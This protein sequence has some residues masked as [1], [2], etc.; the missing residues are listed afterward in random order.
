ML[1]PPLSPSLLVQSSASRSLWLHTWHPR[2]G[3]GLFFCTTWCPCVGFTWWHRIGCRRNNKQWSQ[4]NLF[5]V[6]PAIA[7]CKRNAPQAY[8]TVHYNVEHFSLSAIF[9]LKAS[10][11]FKQPAASQTSQTHLML[12]SKADN[13]TEIP[14]YMPS[15]WK[16]SNESS[17]TQCSGNHIPEKRCETCPCDSLWEHI[18]SQKP[19]CVSFPSDDPLYNEW[20]HGTIKP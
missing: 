14:F 1:L 18:S 16:A 3:R 12:L 11:L 5:G 15:V 10:Q 13:N 4:K 2:R 6:S 17:S 20:L 9:L 7:P 8:T 19:R